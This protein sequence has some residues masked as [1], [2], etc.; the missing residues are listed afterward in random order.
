VPS[1]SEIATPFQALQFHL[2]GICAKPSCPCPHHFLHWMG[3]VTMHGSCR[4]RTDEEDSEG[5][6]EMHD[7]GIWQAQGMKCV[8]TE[9]RGA[10]QVAWMTDLQVQGP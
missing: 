10:L 8:T 3:L 5:R 6:Y 1:A 9:M 4:V 7:K 2:Q